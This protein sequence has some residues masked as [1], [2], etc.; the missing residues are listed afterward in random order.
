MKFFV[1][2]LALSALIGPAKAAVIYYDTHAS[3]S[4]TIDVGA[5]YANLFK[6]AKFNIP[7]ATLTGASVKVIHRART[8]SI[9]VTNTGG[10]T[11]SIQALDSAFTAKQFHA[12]HDS[13]QPTVNLGDAMDPESL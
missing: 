13:S 12:G 11:A 8:G 2:F 10:I 9:T 5:S 4:N 1:T 6:I 7:Q 3:Y